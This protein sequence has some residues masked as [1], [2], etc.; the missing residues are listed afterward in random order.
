MF[1]SKNLKHH[2]QNRVGLMLVM[3][4]LTAVA[5]WERSVEPGEGNATLDR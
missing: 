5:V 4:S 1:G 2:P 3:F